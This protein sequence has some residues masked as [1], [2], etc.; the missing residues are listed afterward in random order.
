M[1]GMLDHYFLGPASPSARYTPNVPVY[2]MIVPT[3]ST[4]CY[5]FLLENN[6]ASGRPTFLAGA[7]GAGKTMLAAHVSAHAN[8]VYRINRALDARL[9][10]RHEGTTVEQVFGTKLFGLYEGP[11]L[12][13][14]HCSVF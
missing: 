1:C 7:S 12:D 14:D 4:E 8:V 3:S 6:L 5:S 10:L 2:K 13:C 9:D 11:I